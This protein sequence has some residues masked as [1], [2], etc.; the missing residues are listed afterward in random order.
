MRFESDRTPG[1]ERARLEL[2]ALLY[3]ELRSDER[4]A[5][6]GHLATCP[7]CRDE[8]VQLGEGRALL[9]HWTVPPPASKPVPT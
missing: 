3:G 5:L 4:D 9:A 2:P 8:L 6:E 1:C 7:A